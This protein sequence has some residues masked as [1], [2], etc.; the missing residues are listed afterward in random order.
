MYRWRTPFLNR[1]VPHEAHGP[2]ARL[3]CGSPGL[4]LVYADDPRTNNDVDAGALPG[5]QPSREPESL[6]D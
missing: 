1:C 2:V 4:G 6:A 3:Y 5:Y